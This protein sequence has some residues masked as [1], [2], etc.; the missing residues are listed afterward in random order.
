MVLS[1]GL[2][3]QLGLSVFWGVLYEYTGPCNSD[4]MYH[5]T[6]IYP[7]V[8][9]KSEEDAFRSKRCLIINRVQEL[10]MC[11]I[12]LLSRFGF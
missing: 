1:A 4:Q 5:P 10:T 8:T 11:R 12:F 7:V 2:S 9:V 6:E 3:V